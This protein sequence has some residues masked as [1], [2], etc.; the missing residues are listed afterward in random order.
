MLYY[1]HLVMLQGMKERQTPYRVNVELPPDLGK[2]LDST[3]AR[4]R[5]RGVRGVGPSAVVRLALARLAA[6]EPEAVVDE[7]IQTR[8]S[9]SA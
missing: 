7:L 2:W 3:M 6:S 1:Q 5:A 8:E 9:E 4:T